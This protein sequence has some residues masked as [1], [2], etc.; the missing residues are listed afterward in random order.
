LPTPPLPLYSVRDRTAIT[1]ALPKGMRSR[2][3]TV[4][5]VLLLLAACGPYRLMRPDEITI[6]NYEPRPVVV[7]ATC[8]SLVNRAANVGMSRFSDNE[9]R[10][11]EFCQQQHLIRAQEEEAASKKIEA[12]AEAANFALRL[13]VVTLGAIIGI[14]A[15]LF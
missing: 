14:L 4:L 7:P 11:V 5:A 15:W 13:T 6:P 9:T 3:L 12:H 10:E 1:N 2:A 8:D